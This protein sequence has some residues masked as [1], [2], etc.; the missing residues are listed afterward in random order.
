MKNTQRE[1]IHQLLLLTF[2]SSSAHIAHADNSQPSG[3]ELIIEETLVT[4]QRR[5]E[6]QKTVP[7]SIATLSGGNYD[8][9]FSSGEDIQAL[10]NRV[11]SLYVESSNGRIA[12]RFYI[13]GL[14][15]VDFDLAASQPV[16]IIFD[17]VVQ[18]NVVLKSFPLFDIE[19][20]EV[21]RGPQGALFGRNTTAGIV[22]FQSRKPTAE[23]TGYI[24]TGYGTYDTVNIEGAV[25]GTL[26]ED[27]ILGRLSLLSQ[28]REDWIDNAFTGENNV[29]GGYQELAGRA[30]LLLTPI[31]NLSA[32][33]NYHTRDLDGSQTAFRANVFTT[34]SNELN[35]NYDRDT[36]FYD[37]G[38]D[39][40]QKYDG[41]GASLKID[42][43]IGEVVFTSVSAQEEA[44]GSNTGDIDG[45][46]AGTGPGFIPFS[47]ATIDAGDIDQFTQEFR[48]ANNEDAAWNWQ[49]GT[50]Y[51]DSDLKVTTDAGFNI[52][53]VNHE[54]TSWAIF[55][56]NSYKLTSDLNFSAGIR[57]TD[58]EREFNS[59]GIETIEV[60]DDQVSWD[61]GLN[62]AASDDTSIYT[63][64]ADGFRAPTIQGRDVA[65]F[66]QPSVADSETILSYE[67][68]VK[69]DLFSKRLR[70]NA[71]LFYYT[72]DGL[73]LSAIG[74]A[75]NSN[76]LLNADE[77]V[78]QGFEVDIEAVPTP[79]LKITSGF[80]YNDTEIKDGDLFTA[81]CGSGQ[82]TPTDPLNESGDANI[83]GNPFQGAP[84]TTFNFTLQY[85]IPHGDSGFWF[86][87]TDWAYQGETNLALYE[88]EE[89]ITDGQ[90]EGGL[91]LGYKNIKQAYEF[92]LFGRNITDEDNVKGFV[93]FNNNTGFVNEPRIVGVEFNYT[94]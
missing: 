1:R 80:S 71:A 43:T 37:D 47:S 55:A 34:G 78:G 41:S 25:G 13:R 14:G 73:Q 38:D 90:Y 5:E 79:N 63:R 45:G 19:Q 83:N 94:F 89:F 22:K 74:G 8:T 92:A 50:F 88:S 44:N 20:V 59:E 26:V 72:I 39:N 52:A 29:F 87:F 17:D 85:Q 46:V 18:E 84:K 11:P 28:N 81:V 4:A 64:V 15:N 6:Q 58:D 54:N 2:I 76:R 91:R 60:S 77:G 53:T 51:F 33:L 70:L 48:L 40:T 12:P 35:E 9:L 36:V 68:G 21:I 30:Q 65:F 3:A 75:S 56:H 49:V 24:R 86:V 57:F 23:T 27:K 93:D 16:S 66:G 67:L 82:C 69:S 62:Y 31:D 61:I 7:I 10:A 32:L 42:W